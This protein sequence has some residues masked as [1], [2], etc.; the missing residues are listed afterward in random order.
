MTCP[1]L[2]DHTKATPIS[3]ERIAR[4]MESALEWEVIRDGLDDLIAHNRAR[5]AEFQESIDRL[6]AENQQEGFTQ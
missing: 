6:K 3:F 5:V 4:R 2:F 1:M